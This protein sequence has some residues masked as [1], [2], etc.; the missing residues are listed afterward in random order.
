V[1]DVRDVFSQ[2]C[3]GLATGFG[4]VWS[5]D[6]SAGE[7][8]RID[9]RTLHV[10]AHIQ[11]SPADSEGLIATD[12][13][14]VWVVVQDSTSGATRLERINPKT[15]TIAARIL[16]PEGSVAAATGFGSVWVTTASSDTVERV[17]PRAGK[18]IG[19]IKV[20]DGP[21]FLAAGE[22]AVWVLNQSDGSVSK[23]DPVSNQVV[24]TIPVDVPGEGGIVTIGLGS[25]WIS[26]PGTPFVRIDPH[27]DRVIERYIGS[28]GDAI[29]P[30]FGSVWL[31]NRLFGTV[32][33]IRP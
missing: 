19:T 22:G 4:S 3:A 31:S 14:G 16:V 28:G 29:I 13:Y 25:V 30:G 20:H 26:M 21:R 32:W 10:V 11:A 7:I 9:P 2:P 24:A 6:C 12:A 15:N 27:T 18:V 5:P 17:D 33:R 23:I 1:A 8:D